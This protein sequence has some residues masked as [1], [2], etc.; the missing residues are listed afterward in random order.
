[1][2]SRAYKDESAFPKL[3]IHCLRCGEQFVQGQQVFELQVLC[4]KCRGY[5]IPGS[6]NFE[7][8]LRLRYP[9]AEA[10]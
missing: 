5:G 3:H 4:R 6:I 1:M 8:T 10:A 7:K 9:P 2:S